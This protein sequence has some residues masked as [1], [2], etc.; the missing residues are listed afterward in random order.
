MVHEP[1]STRELHG[2]CLTLSRRASTAEPMLVR[3]A[4]R[5]AFDV[6]LGSSWRK[7]SSCVDFFRE[8]VSTQQLSG[9][10]KTAALPLV[11]SFLSAIGQ[12]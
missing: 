4:L 12:L 3:L 6:G 2:S 9:T 1:P 5:L 10:P 7:G 11:D 8:V